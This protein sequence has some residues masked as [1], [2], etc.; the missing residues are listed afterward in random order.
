MPSELDARGIDTAIPFT[1]ADDGFYTKDAPG[2]E[3]NQVITHKGEKGKANKAVIEKLKEAG[4]LIGL[5]RLKHQYPHSWR[6][7]KPIIF[8]NT[9]QW[10]VYM[11]KTLTGEGDT[12][13]SRALNA[14]DDTRFVPGRGQ[15]RLRSMIE[16]RPDWVLSRQRAWGVPITVFIHKDTAEVLKDEA[17]NKRIFEAFVP[18][19]PMPGSQAAPRNASSATTTRPTSGTWS[20]TSSMSG[21]IPAPPMP[22]AWKSAKT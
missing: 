1:V 15:N 19:A 10:F 21:S 22:S 17:V 5:G 14:I 16:N 12:L 2:F 4:N 18:K 7:K 9:P 13:R 8:R 6:S 20:R 11:D 3:G